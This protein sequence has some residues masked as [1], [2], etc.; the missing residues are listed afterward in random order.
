MGF[1]DRKADQIDAEA[2]AGYLEFELGA[3]RLKA[4]KRFNR[5]HNTTLTQLVSSAWTI[6]L[7]RATGLN[8]PVQM[9]NNL[10]DRIEFETV[11]GDFSSALPMILDINPGTRVSDLFQA[12]DQ[13]M[14]DLQRHKRCNVPELLRSLNSQK[15]SNHDAHNWGAV[16]IDSNDRDSLLDTSG[17]TDRVISLKPEDRD[18]PGQLLILV[19]KTDER[20]SLH[21]LYDTR[22]LT[23]KTMKLIVEGMDVLLKQILAAPECLIGELLIPKKLKKRLLV[24]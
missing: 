3:K 8:L 5:K 7:W 19:V 21:Y 14:T 13:A 22:C 23:R 17:F 2:K 24:R 20:L 15:G 10:R 9:V 12:Y 4:L 18:P 16:T 11:M 1:Q 6:L